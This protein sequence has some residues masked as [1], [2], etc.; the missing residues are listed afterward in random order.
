MHVRGGEAQDPAAGLGG[1][2]LG[3]VRD[4]GAAFFE[5]HCELQDKTSSPFSSNR[6]MF[7]TEE[8]HRKVVVFFVNWTFDVHSF[9]VSAADGDSCRR[10]RDEAVSSPVCCSLSMCCGHLPAAGIH[11]PAQ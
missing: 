3:L 7:E 10:R 4:Q 9:M 5:S 11:P 2:N 1:I 6:T 8:V